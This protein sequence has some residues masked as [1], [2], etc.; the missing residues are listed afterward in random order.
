MNAGYRYKKKRS[1]RTNSTKFVNKLVTK[2]ST[3][4]SHRRRKSLRRKGKR[5][6]KRRKTSRK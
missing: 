3:I 1:L 4:K 5:T 6:R 2:S